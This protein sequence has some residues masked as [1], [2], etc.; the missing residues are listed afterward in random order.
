VNDN[1]LLINPKINPASQSGII[2]RIIN[3]TFPTSLGVLAAYLMRSGSGSVT[4]ADEQLHPVCP[5]RLEELVVSLRRPRIVGLSALTVN[6]ARAYDIARSVKRIDPEATVVLGGIHP[7]VLP[8]EALKSDGVDVVVRGEG[9][10][11]FEELVRLAASG[12]D[13]SRV[14]GI[15]LKKEG[16]IAHNP[17]RP[18]VEDLDK[19]PPFPYHLFEKDRLAYPSFG[20]ILTSRGCPYGCIFCSSRSVSGTRYRY[21]SIERTVSEISLLAGRYGQKIVWMMDDNIAADRNRFLKLLDGIMAAGLHRKVSFHGSMRGDNISYEVLDKAKEANFRMISFG[22]ETASETLMKIIS[23]GETVKEV[24]EAIRMT[25]RKGISAATTV[26]FGLPKETRK[27][28]YDA[29][30]LVGSLPLS[31]VRFNTLIPYPGTPAFDRLSREG[32]ICVRKDWENFAVQYMWEGDD[33]AYVPD[34]T[35]RYELMFDTMFA[36]LSFYL[37]PRNI[38]RMFSSSFAGG[39]VVTV[40]GRWYRLPVTVYRMSLVLF[41]LLKRFARISYRMLAGR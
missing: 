21:F 32:K 40:S 7:T 34:G 10:E 13:Y 31:S 4:I 20:S 18:L 35:N 15:S 36:N 1:V 2:N 5:K 9:E 29:M 8:E 37:N 38:A 39:N 28:R 25:D 33:L 24:A 19:I 3:T 11:T 30:R 12:K 26:I 22:L 41:Y 16:I 23:K 14:A 6:S 17:P 27:D